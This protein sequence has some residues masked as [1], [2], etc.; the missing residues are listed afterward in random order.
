MDGSDEASCPCAVKVDRNKLCDQYFDCPDGEDEIGCNGCFSSSYSCYSNVVNECYRK[1]QKCDSM[2][3]CS[4][5]EDERDCL[6][7][8]SN[9]TYSVDSPL[10]RSL[11]GVLHANLKD[12]WYPVCDDHSN[13][14]AKEACEQEIG[15]KLR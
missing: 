2:T 12:E 9:G 6:L 1:D 4:N 5:G 14:M 13:T 8:S 10:R 15:A 3:Q 7:L 11:D